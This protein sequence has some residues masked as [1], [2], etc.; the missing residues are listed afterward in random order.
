MKR[1]NLKILKMIIVIFFSL[2]L[3][4][5]AAAAS[6]NIAYVSQKITKAY[7]YLNMGIRVANAR[8]DLKNG[9][10]T[11]ND[12]IKALE[13]TAMD[14]EEKNVLMFIS[15]TRDQMAGVLKQTYT[16]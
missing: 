2:V 16:A 10:D 11:L 4:N 9:M 14:E 5:T 12:A 8:K 3:V 7:F 15:F 13:K 1:V 6:G